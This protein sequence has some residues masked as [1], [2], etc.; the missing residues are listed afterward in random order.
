MAN[1]CILGAGSFG[2][3]LAVM[4]DGH[5]HRVTLWSHRAERAQWLCARRCDPSKLK[6]IRLAETIHISSHMGEAIEN[7]EIILFA[8]PSIY[9]RS[10][11]AALKKCLGR[12][13]PLIVDVAKG[14]EADTLMTL[15]QQLKEELP[16]LTVSV[17][18]G[19]SHAEEV[20]LGL[21][22]TCVL[23]ADD[24][25]TA[26]YLQTVFNNEV[27]RTYSSPDMI[28]IEL[29]GALKNVIALAAGIAD[30]LGFGD[31]TK[32]ALITRGI[33]EMTRLG[34]KMGA[35]PYTFAGLAGTGDLIV[36]CASRH[37]RN[38]RAGYLIGQGYT[39]DEAMEE[40]RMVVEGVYSA[41]A[42]LAL[43]EK[44]DVEM[45]I[46]EQVNR[47]LFDGCSAL[48]AM[49]AL[50][51]RAAK[52]EYEDSCWERVSEHEHTDL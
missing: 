14:L 6:G 11:A 25:R 28:G 23:G 46:V 16:G 36:T 52:D 44:Y 43:A 13:T 22:T 26:R 39:C 34:I 49:R 48:E 21:P 7:A 45:P 8:V 51:S 29:G 38:R 20:A 1:I 2:M 10:T 33:A 5:G 41:R 17:L 31:N 3:A 40:V 50:M 24:R 42:A 19:P 32:A 4:L 27:F 12:E 47:I 37:S 15:S 9:T 18:S 35:D 30:G